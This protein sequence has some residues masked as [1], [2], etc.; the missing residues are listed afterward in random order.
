MIGAERIRGDSRGATR[1]AVLDDVSGLKEH[2]L[3]QSTHRAALAIRMP[4]RDAGSGADAG[5]R[6]PRAWRTRRMSGPNRACRVVSATGS[7]ASSR[8]TRCHGICAVMLKIG[9]TSGVLDRRDAVK[10]V[11]RDCQLVRGTE[12]TVIHVGVTAG[13]TASAARR[14]VVVDEAP[15]QLVAVSVVVGARRGSAGCRCV[16]A[17]G[18]GTARAGRCLCKGSNSP[19]GRSNQK[20]ARSA[21]TG[22]RSSNPPRQLAHL[23]RAART[24]RSRDRP[25]C[26]STPMLPITG[27]RGNVLPAP[28]PMT[29]CQEPVGLEDGI[30]CRRNGSVLRALE[31]DDDVLTGESG[32]PFRV[33]HGG[34]GPSRCG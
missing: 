27:P 32:E 23:I 33:R 22:I 20:P 17:A 5:G 12:R 25:T 4:D 26:S 16:R 19:A 3:A 24:V 21:A 7:A 11:S 31:V 18:P 34:T 2:G 13:G 15:R 1:I 10:V 28:P 9:A 29:R 8:T 14:A 6:A 30:D